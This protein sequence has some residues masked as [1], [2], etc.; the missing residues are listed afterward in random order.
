MLDARGSFKKHPERQRE[1]AQAA[2]VLGDPPGYFSEQQLGTWSELITA[3]PRD[4]ITESDR[5]ALELA[6]VM[7]AQFRLDPAE[8]PATKLVRLEALLGKFG[9][10]PADRARIGGRKEKP[11]GNPFEN[12]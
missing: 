2:G 9:M 12:L 1:D 5:F 6:A 4:V 3:A 8:F 7:L 10:T 11:R